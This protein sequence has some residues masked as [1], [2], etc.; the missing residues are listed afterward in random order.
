MTTAWDNYKQTLS[1]FTPEEL[2]IL[3]Q[4]YQKY[5]DQHQRWHWK[6]GD[7]M[8]FDDWWRAMADNE[9]DKRE[10]K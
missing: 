7:V 2:A 1:G 6:N 5:C 8:S 10:G 4:E 9:M 3:R